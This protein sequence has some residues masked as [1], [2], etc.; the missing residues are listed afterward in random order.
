MWRQVQ[1]FGCPW[2][3]WIRFDIERIRCAVFT[4]RRRSHIEG[5]IREGFSHKLELAKLVNAW[6]RQGAVGYKAEDPRCRL[7]SWPA[8]D[9][10]CRRLG[11][12]HDGIRAQVWHEDSRIPSPG[13][14]YF[15]ASEEKLHDVM[16]D[17]GSQYR[18][19]K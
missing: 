10:S 3:L 9:V 12:T 5:G 13:H 4:Y 17:V 6:P 15:E 11:S 7:G 8:S 1:C 14:M 2:L 18:R 19:Q 16:T